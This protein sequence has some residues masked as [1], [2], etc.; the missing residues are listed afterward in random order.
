MSWGD[1]DN[2]S[3]H[4]GPG[5]VPGEPRGEPRTP[6][7]TLHQNQLRST[8]EPNWV[9]IW[10]YL[11]TSVQ[12]ETRIRTVAAANTASHKPHAR[13]CPGRTC[14][15][16]TPSTRT[17]PRGLRAQKARTLAALSRLSLRHGA[18]PGLG[19]GARDREAC[20][21]GAGAAGG[22]GLRESLGLARV[23]RS[24]P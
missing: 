8:G 21:A 3:W 17:A 5:S 24:V 2:S 18:A 19:A 13:G 7:V 16:P 11:P 6:E 20:G 12:Q 9:D 22:S 10:M 23:A 1:G 4:G 14:A 15:A